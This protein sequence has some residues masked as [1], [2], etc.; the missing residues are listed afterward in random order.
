MLNL[1]L[2]LTRV[3][4]AFTPVSFLF[5]LELDTVD[6]DLKLEKKAYAIA[7]L[8]Q[9]LKLL[10]SRRTRWYRRVTSRQNQD[11]GDDR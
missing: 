6:D 10:G 5:Y 9:L 2:W 11:Q 4:T 7:A 8:N 1:C 3:T